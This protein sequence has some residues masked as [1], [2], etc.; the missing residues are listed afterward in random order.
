M[1]SPTYPEIRKAR[2]FKKTKVNIQPKIDLDTIDGWYKEGSF[3]H[4]GP[5]QN[6]VKTHYYYKSKLPI[7]RSPRVEEMVKFKKP[8]GFALKKKCKQ[9][10]KLLAMYSDLSLMVKK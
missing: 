10:L 9:C 5:V 1:T 2:R 6:H 3:I 8:G 7:C 4:A